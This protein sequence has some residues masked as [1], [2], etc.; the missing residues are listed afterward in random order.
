[1]LLITALVM[2]LSNCSK[3]DQKTPPPAA[4]DVPVADIGSF[5]LADR[6]PAGSL[7]YLG[8]A[9]HNQ[10]F[11]Q[12]QWGQ[13]L[14]D[15]AA[16]AIYDQVTSFL[17]MLP[18]DIRGPIDDSLT[19]AGILWRHPV[20]AALVDVTPLA[21]N[22]PPKVSAVLLA[23]VGQDRQ[24]F[25]SALNAL[26][27]RLPEGLIQKDGDFS[28]IAGPVAVSFGYLGDTFVLTVGDDTLAKLRQLAP[29]DTLASDQTFAKRM[30]DV[31]KSSAKG[32]V[33]ADEAQF[34]F[35]VDFDKLGKII[36]SEP[37]ADGDEMITLFHKALK[38]AGVDQASCLVS[39][40][41]VVDGGV[42]GRTRLHTPAPHH[43]V[44]GLLVSHQLQQS[45]L[46]DIPSDADA[47]GAIAFSITD[48][49][50]FI[51]E[52]GDTPQ[53]KRFDQALAKAKQETGVS[54]KEDVI[55]NVGDV[56]TYYVVMGE[57]FAISAKLKDPAKF[58]AAMAKLMD[59]SKKKDGPVSFGSQKLGDLL[60]YYF[61][62]PESM[63]IPGLAGGVKP[64]M[65]VYKDR[66]LFSV[67]PQMLQQAAMATGES[68]V[69]NHDFQATLTHV[70]PNANFLGYTNTAR[71]MTS[72]AAMSASL[73]PEE[74]GAL[75]K[76]LA[77][78]A[79]YAR[80]DV[81]S[82][83]SDDYG[84]VSESYGS[85]PVVVSF[86]G[87]ATVAATVAIVMPALAKARESAKAAGSAMNLSNIGKEMML[88]ANSNNDRWPPSMEALIKEG[89]SEQQLVSP[90]SGKKSYYYLPFKTAPIDSKPVVV[91][92]ED[93]ANYHNKG[94]AALMSDLSVKRFKS[95]DEF[96]QELERAE[97]LL[98]KQGGKV[99]EAK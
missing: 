13:M 28:K 21:G 30:A 26:L 5:P 50:R 44:L 52:A 74:A 41:R 27:K 82:I 8:W 73:P 2:P 20:A 70:N 76:N 92:Y 7:V 31:G 55:E 63:S 36:P 81:S 62:M 9:G 99:Q 91:M 54:V 35:Y 86:G 69:R 78:L 75:E 3:R 34:A 4:P 38:T 87:I 15:P 77:K 19:L 40:V 37:G 11:N 22:N 17:Q 12:S 18:R 42:Y 60:I 45:D 88:Y 51:Q 39:S 72:M 83:W 46:E 71:T 43:G 65:C 59:Y 1:M 58:S 90:L 94:T 23:Q 95:M 64:S 97:S 67:N 24:R 61:E 85:H 25:D 53:G 14:K 33:I 93:P 47:A 89:M 16:G 57:K 66:L 84:V 98:A 80:P 48:A 68:L 32:K 6:L 56:W 79:V 96:N 49:I 10:T 29:A